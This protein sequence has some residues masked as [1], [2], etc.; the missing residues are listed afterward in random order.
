MK[1]LTVTAYSLLILSGCFS[2]TS[3]LAQ[4]LTDSTSHSLFTR[5]TPV[6]LKLGEGSSFG[7]NR[8]DG[9]FSHFEVIDQRPD[10]ARIGIHAGRYRS[11]GTFNRQMVFSRPVAAEI[12]A[13]LNQHFAR[14]GAPYTGLIVLRTLWL[15]DASYIREE[16]MKAPEKRFE[17]TKIRLKAEVY[18]ARDSVYIPVFRFDSL[19]ASTKGSYTRFSK[20]LTG[21][22]DQLADSSSLVIAGRRESGRFISFDEIR[23]FNQSR[24]DIAICKDSLL[25]KGVYA[26]FEEFRNNTPS[27]LNYDIKK[28]EEN[29]LIYIKETGGRTYYSHSA[30]GYCDGK[31]IFIMKDGVLR[32]AW[33]EGK[34][35]Y[36]FGKTKIETSDA[37]TDTRLATPS[38]VS[39]GPGPSGTGPSGD[40]IASLAHSL[41]SSAAN[42]MSRLRI[43]AVDMDNGTVY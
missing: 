16:L 6:I 35:W 15:S 37:L 14:P 8:L 34:A 25:R 24:F 40:L 4:S 17:R 31:N 28:D 22:L 33:R 29:L 43:F 7:M 19:Y 5:Y 20:D 1:T 3:A 2:R 21:I 13:Y 27:I 38:Q 23:A 11:A 32:P 36:F 39:A 26:S 41:I 30:W 9:L 18:A 10:T 12:A 42:D